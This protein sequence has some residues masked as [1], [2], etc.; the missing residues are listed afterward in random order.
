MRDSCSGSSGRSGKH[1]AGAK[2]LLETHIYDESGAFRHP[3]PQ[4][5]RVLA[6][7]A[8]PLHRPNPRGGVLRRSKL[9]DGRASG[10]Q[11]REMSVFSSSASSSVR[12]SGPKTRAAR[13]LAGFGIATPDR[14]RSGGS[15]GSETR[16]TPVQRTVG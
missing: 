15:L 11:N 7:S 6:A 14:R 4:P 10:C 16:F 12:R 2:K 13:G 1:L 8:P 5:L 3:L 9:G